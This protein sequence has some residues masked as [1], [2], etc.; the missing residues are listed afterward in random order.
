MATTAAA[1]VAIA[2]RQTLAATATKAATAGATAEKES[3][4][5]SNNHSRRERNEKKTFESHREMLGVF[6]FR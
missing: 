5:C 1:G 4:I 2:A 3:N 6:F